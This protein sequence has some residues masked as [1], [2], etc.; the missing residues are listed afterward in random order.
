MGTFFAERLADEIRCPVYDFRVVGEIRSRGN[1]A[2]EPD[3][4]HD[5]VE[6]A[7]TGKANLGQDVDCALAGS[8]RRI[9]NRDVSPPKGPYGSID[10]P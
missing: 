6:I 1:K 4:A 9:L 10:R 3:A 5:P 7:V 2:A 8:K